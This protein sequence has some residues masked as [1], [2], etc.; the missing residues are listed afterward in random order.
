MGFGS[1]DESEQDNQSIDTDLDEESV[2]S[3]ESDHKGRIEFE[4]GASNDELIDRLKDI[5]DDG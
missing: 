2:D 4:N 5:K 1:Y 3:R